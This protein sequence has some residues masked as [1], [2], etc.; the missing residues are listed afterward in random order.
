M[1]IVTARKANQGF[2]ELLSD[3]E[4]GEEILITK[5]GRPVAVL[6]PYQRRR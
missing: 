5:H 4:G 2:S 6:S 1:R 3:V